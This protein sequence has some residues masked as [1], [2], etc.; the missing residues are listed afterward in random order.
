MIIE[1][2]T[3]IEK[4][5]VKGHTVYVKRED[6]QGDGVNSPAW[7]KLLATREMVKNLPDDRP[8]IALNT[9]GSF[10][11]WALSA[12]CKELDVEFHMVHPKTK[13]IHDDYMDICSAN[14]THFHELR[15]NMFKIMYGQLGKIATDNNYQQLAYAYNSPV[16]LKFAAK[17]M[18]NTLQN[19]KVKFDNIVIPSGSGVTLSGLAAGVFRFNPNANIYTCSVGTMG[20]V[21]DQLTRYPTLAARRDQ[22]HNTVSEYEFNDLMKWCEVPFPC[23]Q[24]WDK[25]AWHWLEQN[26]DKLEGRTL[27][28]NLGGHNEFV[29]PHRVQPGAKYFYKDLEKYQTKKAK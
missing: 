11:G 14:G 20:G 1:E 25:K 13:L 19:A 28:W 6:L 8:L 24:F 27:F 18:L 4:Y 10:S 3:P 23:N 17:R 22:I 29:P 15:P 16:Y 9:Y 2:N 5:K 21:N 26:I 7:G 12:I